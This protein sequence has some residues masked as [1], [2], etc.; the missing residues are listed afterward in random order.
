VSPPFDSSGNTSL[1]AATIMYEILCILA[2]KIN[3]ESK[4]KK[5]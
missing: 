3:A 2:E 5:G 4:R 1:I